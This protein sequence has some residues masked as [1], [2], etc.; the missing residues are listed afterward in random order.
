MCGKYVN[1]FPKLRS[2]IL[3]YIE[4]WPHTKISKVVEAMEI[5]NP[6]LTCAGCYNGIKPIQSTVLHLL[7]ER[8]IILNPD[9]T[10]D[11][12]WSSERIIK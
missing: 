9:R 6:E 12:N 3:D 4:V 7:H 2:D 11:I 5:T 8:A 10:L 1:D